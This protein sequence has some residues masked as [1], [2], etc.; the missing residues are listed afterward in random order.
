[1]PRKKPKLEVHR[2]QQVV[3]MTGCR[4]FLEEINGL[5]MDGWRIVPGSYYHTRVPA[6]PRADTPTRFISRDGVTFEDSYFIA[7]ERDEI[8]DPDAAKRAIEAAEQRQLAEF[9]VS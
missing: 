5:L 4:R 7:I 8:V 9:G 3:T 6:V 2:L 1:M